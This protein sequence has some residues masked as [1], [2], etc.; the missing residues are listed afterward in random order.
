MYVF[1]HLGSATP[2]ASKCAKG[3]LYGDAPAYLPGMGPKASPPSA[4]WAPLAVAAVVVGGVL[5]WVAKSMTPVLSANPSSLANPTG[6]WVWTAFD[7]EYAGSTDTS[8]FYSSKKEALASAKR[9]FPH[10]HPEGDVYVGSEYG[11]IEVYEADWENPSSLAVGDVVEFRDPSPSERGLQFEVLELRGERVLVS[12]RDPHWRG[13]LIVPQSVY[14]VADLKKVWEENPAASAGRWEKLRADYLAARREYDDLTIK[15][16]VKYGKREWASRTEKKKLDQLRKRMDRIGDKMLA[17]LDQVSPRDWHSGVPA[18][19]VYG[20]LSWEDAI[21]PLS[22]PL[23]VTPPLAY[24]HTS[25]M[26]T[27]PRRPNDGYSPFPAEAIDPE[28]VRVGTDH[29]ME[30]TTSRRVARRIALDHLREDPRYY[31]KLGAVEGAFGGL[32]APNPKKRRSPP[33]RATTD[34]WEQLV[35]RNG[36]VWLVVPNSHFLE[37]PEY[38]ERYSRAWVEERFGP[39]QPATRNENPSLFAPNWNWPLAALLIPGVPPLAENP[40]TMRRTEFEIATRDGGRA[41][42]VGYVEGD[43]ATHKGRYFWE[44]THLPTGMSLSAYP[45]HETKASALAHLHKLAT[46]GPPEHV[47][48]LLE[49]YPGWGGAKPGHV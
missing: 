41:T 34:V 1:A 31:D 49:R 44:F 35:D 8:S 7:V 2:V 48:H 3:V 40:R 46:E 22:E 25:P 32:F 38:G 11:W 12:S 21:R 13:A 28:Q 45:V 30:H 23:S 33:A 42:R 10:L 47:K 20:S 14:L 43:F 24:G 4:A 19:W 16:D 6:R 9:A 27:N 39:L 36:L 37:D 17:M 5:W 29:E 18:H 26:R 15:L